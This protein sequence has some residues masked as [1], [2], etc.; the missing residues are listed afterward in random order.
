MANM[1]PLILFRGE[2]DLKEWRPHGPRTGGLKLY[3][4]V[5]CHL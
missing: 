3:D 2:G 1:T 4:E 5:P